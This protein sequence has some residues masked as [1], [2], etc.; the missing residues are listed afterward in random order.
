MKNFHLTLLALFVANFA[1]GQMKPKRPTASSTSPVKAENLSP[2]MPLTPAVP[3]AA[4]QFSGTQNFRSIATLPKPVSGQPKLQALISEETGTPY[5][6]RGTVDVDPAKSTSMQ[7][8]DYLLAAKS[9]LRLDNPTQEMQV[10]KTETDELGYQHIR[11]QQ[12]WQGVPVYGAEA[13]LHEKNEQF[14]LFN[15]RFHTSPK[16]TDVT[17]SIQAQAAEQTALGAVSSME[18]VKTLTAADLRLVNTTQQ[19]KAELAIFYP[20]KNEPHLTWHV[21]V[22]PNIAARYSYFVD[23]KSGEIL[24]YHTEICKI[25]GHVHEVGNGQT[26]SLSIASK[27]PTDVLAN[28]KMPP[29]D[30]PATANANDLLGQTRLVNTYKVGNTYFMID[31]AESMFNSSQSSFPDNGVGVIWTI[32]AQNTSPENNN[33]GAV[34]ITSNNNTWNN[35]KAVSAYFHAQK[36]FEYFKNTFG[37]NS[38]NG[39]GG[40]IVSLINVVESDNTQMD[41]AFW[42]GQAMF[43]GNGNQ[44]F[45]AP[46]QKALDVSGHEMSHGVI[47]ATANLEYL[48]ESGALN[49]SFADIFGAMIDRDDWKMGEDVTNSQFYPTG[50]LRDLS[51]PHNG[52]NN[53]NDNGWQPAHVNEK[54]NGN[55]DN[56]G[57]HINSGIVNKAFFLFATNASVGKNKAEKVYYRA[58]DLYLT[59]SSNFVDCRIA[60]VQAATDLHG[61]NSAEV[62]A[63]KAAFDAVGIGSS[64]GTTTPPDIQTNPGEDFV[65]MTDAD[66]D[67]LYIFAA[68][69]TDVFNPLTSIS[70]LSRPSVTDNGSLIVYIDQDNK[71]RAITINWSAGTSSNQ[72]I[73]QE[74]IWTNVAISKD[75]SRLAALTTD[76]DDRVWIYDFGLQTW[77]DFELYNPTTAT[78]GQDSYNVVYADVLEWDVTGQWVMYDALSHINTTGNDIEYWD[79]G[80]MYVWNGS[81]FGDG[82]IDKLFSSLPEKVSV[83]D[84]TFSKNSDY[85]I[86]FDYFDEFNEEYYLLGANVETG[87]VG[88]IYDQGTD[89]YWPSYSPDDHQIVF[90]ESLSNGTEVL[91]FQSLQSN[92][93]TPTGDPS[94]FV[95][96]GRQGVW[97]ANGN[98]ALAANDLIAQNNIRLYPN[99]VSDGQFNLDFS[100]KKTSEVQVQV[101]DL[102]GRLVLDEKINASAGENHYRISTE[103][104]INGQFFVRISM[105]EG[106]AALK[107]LKN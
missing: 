88:T 35:P 101:F 46:L 104:L 10:T 74:P 77:K 60:V 38:I 93:I 79:I 80:F 82:Y 30:G 86:A 73:S 85:I 95:Q 47:Q 2:I 48:N 9:V 16:L 89:L 15:G 45:T 92:K 102:M 7:V 61:A 107:F 66:S 68:D 3:F 36:A 5:L 70:P 25:A 56:G 98:R 97:F 100:A 81:N 75:G 87:E 78:G 12:Q 1:F 65:A 58:L 54:Y 17:P 21:T 40:N 14:Y 84:P 34:H 19:S 67:Q 50:A 43:Y 8:Q 71:M 39:L 83:G 29:V 76:N 18:T 99:P 20:E 33:F 11:M 105:A 64:G 53:L 51:N 94:V 23:A 44:A 69:G 49:E 57:V 22:V 91:A 103:G 55:Q 13:I 41:N 26:E 52:G 63:A 59:K 90:N 42:N 72:V 32:D 106:Q 27:M 96:G 37:R 4:P 24:S 31:A 6:I 28:S 62:N